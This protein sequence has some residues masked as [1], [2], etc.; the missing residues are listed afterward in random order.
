MIPSTFLA[1]ALLS[2]AP[3][4][5]RTS[6]PAVDASTSTATAE[7]VEILR[8]VLIETLDKA[9]EEKRPS[10]SVRLERGLR[11]DGLVTTLWA[12]GQTV[13]HARAFHLPDVGLFLA[14]DLSLPV[15]K[16][17]QAEPGSDQ[18][19]NDEWERARREVRGSLAPNGMRLR[20]LK[21]G[22]EGLGEIDPKAID[23]VTDVVLGALARH[24]ARIEGL[25]SNETVTVALRLSGKDRSWLHEWS[26][27]EPH[28]LRLRADEE[29]EAEQAQSMAFSAFVMATGHEVREQNLVLQI[30]LADLT[31]PDRATPEL[32]RVAR[33]NRY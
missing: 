27:D 26:E 30:R 10:E 6:P 5:G 3:L 25:G 28:T 9:F 16:K 20:M 21:V 11:V 32:R 7:G 15:V 1:A 17:E 2:A 23:Q 18:P 14:L 33:I 22:G 4:Q 13:Q 8:R 12:D 29:G 19:E 31:A 24:V